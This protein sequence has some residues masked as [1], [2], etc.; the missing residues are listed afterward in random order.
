MNSENKSAMNTAS[1]DDMIPLWELCEPHEL[2]SRK[3]AWS[4]EQT[5]SKSRNLYEKTKTF[6]MYGR[7]ED[8]KPH[9][10]LPNKELKG[11]KI[12]IPGGKATNELPILEKPRSTPK[13]GHRRTNSMVDF[14]PILSQLQSEIQAVHPE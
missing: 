8:Y 10:Q 9:G 6:C 2:F 1:Y 13:R 11:W 14:T 5:Y 4:P 7:L 12:A 3:E